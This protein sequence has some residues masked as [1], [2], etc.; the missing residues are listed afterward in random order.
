MGQ[1]PQTSRWESRFLPWAEFLTLAPAM[2]SQHVVCK[3]VILF[4]WKLFQNR[5]LNGLERN[6]LPSRA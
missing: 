6:L 5:F 3:C 1:V 4:V 2:T